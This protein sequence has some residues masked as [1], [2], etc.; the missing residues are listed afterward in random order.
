MLTELIVEGETATNLSR[1]SLDNCFII[2]QEVL[3]LLEIRV[4]V[5]H[6]ALI[7]QS[8]LD[9]E[10]FEKSTLPGARIPSKSTMTSS[11]GIGDTGAT[12][13][14]T[15]I[16]M[17]NKLG[18]IRYHLLKTSVGHTV[19][20]KRVMTILGVVPVFK[21]TRRAISKKYKEVDSGCMEWIPLS[22]DKGGR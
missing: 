2:I 22:S 21:T 16:D 13:C 20:D 10:S 6:K 4:N 17:L 19:A 11:L 9:R 14:C 5:T 7:I 1:E 18:I 3:D 8:T 15:G 12:I